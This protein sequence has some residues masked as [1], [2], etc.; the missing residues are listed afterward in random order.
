MPTFNPTEL[1]TLVTL[2]SKE[3][4]ANL[5]TL[6]GSESAAIELHQQ[7]LAL[8]ASLMNVTGVIEIALRNAVCENLSH[9]FGVTDWLVRPP[10]P[11]AWKEKEAGNVKKAVDGAKR[12]VYSKL[13]Q[14]AKGALDASAFPSGVPHGL[15]HQARS[16]HR[17]TQI[18]VSHGK[19]VAELTLYFWKKL[20]GPDYEQ[21]LWQPS[22]KKTFP[23]KTLS[24]A[25]IAV[26]LETIYQ[27]R[28]RLAHHEPVLHKRLADTIQAIEFVVQRLGVSKPS[29]TTPLARLVE[30]D[31]AIVR[32]RA[33]ELHAR[34]DAFRTASRDD[35]GST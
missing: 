9:R 2:L 16:K 15:S 28:N 29:A 10:T 22:L 20:Y 30:E 35:A 24:R 21:S 23:D 19:V 3:R 27:A 8:N 6:T 14:A 34:L 33:D 25:D 13:T 7:T 17:R 11:F 4:L 26:P 5:L 32:R 12:A 18:P 1:Q 31:L